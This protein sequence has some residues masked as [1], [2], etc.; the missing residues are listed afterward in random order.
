MPPLQ[1]AQKAVILDGNRVLMVR[2]SADDP[3]NPGRWEF[4]GGRLKE[5][6]ELDDQIRREV[7]EE[8]GLD[9]AP[10]PLLDLWSWEMGSSRV[11]AVSRRCHLNSEVAV[12]PHREPT[13]Y[14]EEQAWWPLTELASLDIIE[15]QIP[16]IKILTQE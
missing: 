4:P 1:F 2:K 6:E 14:L 13:D 8:T 9:I 15:S 5:N 16:T 7:L 11:I 12:A 3:H 10:G